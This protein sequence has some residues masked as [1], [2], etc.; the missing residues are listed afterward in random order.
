MAQGKKK[1][2]KA[3]GTEEEDV[4]VGPYDQNLVG[5]TNGI[6]DPNNAYGRLPSDP[7]IGTFDEWLANQGLVKNR[8][9]GQRK[10]RLKTQWAQAA[11]PSDPE[12][13]NTPE[14]EQFTTENQDKHWNYLM[15]EAGALAGGLGDTQ[16]GQYLNGEYKADTMAGYDAA[17]E[18]SGGGISYTDYLSS[19]GWAPGQQQN[20]LTGA[21]PRDTGNPFTSTSLPQVGG[22]GVQINQNPFTNAREQAQANGL[23]WNQLRP[24][25]QKRLQGAF[26]QPE[27]PAPTLQVGPPTLP[28]IPGQPANGSDGL[29]DAR[30]RFL[31][32][33]PQ[34]RGI[35]TG[36]SFR[37]GR[38]AVYG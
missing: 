6:Y 16:F 31:N 20:T 29:A 15:A 1:K 30:L 24:Q 18:A 34:Q 23:N 7:N 35:N 22:T 36:S 10:D 11:G 38:W 5:P 13:A 3:D 26:G 19:I 17:L 28:N 27:Q 12:Y 25:R 4:V 14:G 2:K 9:K 37:P 33:T 21:P 32:K 8:L